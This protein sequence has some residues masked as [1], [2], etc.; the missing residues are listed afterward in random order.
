MSMLYKYGMRLR[1]FAP[2]CQPKGVVRRED[3][4]SGKYHDILIYDRALTYKEMDDYELDHIR[5]HVPN[6]TERIRLVKAMEYVARQVNDEN[7]F[8][9]WL[10]VGVADQDI[11]YGDLTDEIGETEYW[12]EDDH[13]ADLMGLFLK[14]MAAARKSGGLC[15]DGIVSK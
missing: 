11:S 13:F 9:R 15:C 8:D 14:L 1:G 7:I 2:A 10:S 6:T 3:D 4:P 5:E 12:I